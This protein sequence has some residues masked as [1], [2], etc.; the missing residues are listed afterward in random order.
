MNFAHERV[1]TF[2]RSNLAAHA[3]VGA[4]TLAASQAHAQTE[5]KQCSSQET[6]EIAEAIK[7]GAA[8]W[9]EYETVLEK[10]ADVNI[11]NCLERRFKQ[12]GK[13]LC[14]SR[15]TGFCKSNLGWAS[16]LNKRCHMCPGFLST[17]RKLPGEATRKACYFALL[18]HELAHTCERMHRSIEDMDDAA[19]KFWK[20]K[21][22]EVA[23]DLRACDLY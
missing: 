14:E 6:R 15:A 19:F 16:P 2:A 20:S 8:N 1:R 13:V 11:K 21:H 3:V 9:E 4:L 12:D 17:V 7:W 23:I 22:P 10:A 5:V 18:S